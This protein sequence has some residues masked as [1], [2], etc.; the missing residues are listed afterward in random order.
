VLEI[1]VNLSY[2]YVRWSGLADVEQAIIHG[3][4]MRMVEVALP[5]SV[6][7]SLRFQ[8]QKLL[9]KINDEKT[10]NAHLLGRVCV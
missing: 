5:H 2:L 1:D 3:A 9:K 4:G 6:P 7:S 10:A 8:N